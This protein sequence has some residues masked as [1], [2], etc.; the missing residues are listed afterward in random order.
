MLDSEGVENSPVSDRVRFLDI[1][2]GGTTDCGGGDRG[3]AAA[4]AEVWSSASAG[5]QATERQLIAAP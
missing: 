2:A 3:G 4:A 5:G 1:T